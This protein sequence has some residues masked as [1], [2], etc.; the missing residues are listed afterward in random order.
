MVEPNSEVETPYER[1]QQFNRVVSWLHSFRYRHVIMLLEDV[2]SRIGDRP[3]RVIDVGSSHCK[4]F[5]VLDPLFTIDYTGIDVSASCLAT[6]QRR[7]GDR[8]NF[9]VIL[10][11]A[12]TALP[13]LGKADVVFALETLEH[14]PEHEVVRIVE[15][16]AR[17]EPSL[18]V[19]SVP[20]EV[21]PAIWFKNVG[22]LVSGYMRHQEYRWKETFWAGLFVL[23]KLPPHGTGHKGFD[24]RWLAATIRHNMRIT[25]TKKF[26]FSFAPAALSASVFMIAEPRSEADRAEIG[27]KMAGTLY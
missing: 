3:I 15:T 2:S 11:D 9:R 6:A 8:A 22:S 23:D 20:V 13:R 5:S 12:T 17:S 26:P 27:T 7:Y 24:W 10:E 4:L 21:G 25:Q 19:C 1:A 16:V 14:V 18:F